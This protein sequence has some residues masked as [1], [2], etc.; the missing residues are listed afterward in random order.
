MVVAR[1]VG[2]ACRV[3]IDSQ[4][5]LDRLDPHSPDRDAAIEALHGLLLKAARFE[6][7]RRRALPPPRRGGDYDDLAQQCAD[8][9][10]VAVLRKLRDFRGDSRFTTWAYKFAVYEAGAKSRELAWQPREASLEPGTWA[11]IA[12]NG[13]TPQ[14]DVE[15]REVIATLRD[16]IENDLSP[17]QREVFT[18]VVL[19]EV[20]VDVLAARRRRPAERS[21]RRSTTLAAGCARRSAIAAWPSPSPDE[22]T[23]D[24]LSPMLSSPAWGDRGVAHEGGRRD[25]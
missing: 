22:A 16:A 17:H 19:N 14:Q 6:I 10:L 9:A 11:L 2:D 20:P 25:S 7:H 21:T 15:V 23:G 3:D 4:T 8:D 5:W 1:A 24:P 13:T 12:E 18:A